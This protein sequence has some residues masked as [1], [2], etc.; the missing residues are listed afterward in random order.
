MHG[1]L[2]FLLGIIA[3]IVL[4]VAGLLINKRPDLE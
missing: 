4:V 1:I 2:P 3:A